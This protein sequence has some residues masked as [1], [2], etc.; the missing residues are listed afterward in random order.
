[1][2]GVEVGT[3]G[4]DFRTFMHILERDERTLDAVDAHFHKAADEFDHPEIK[5]RNK[6]SAFYSNQNAAAASAP[7]EMGDL[8]NALAA[9]A[10]A[11]PAPRSLSV[12]VP[13]GAVA[14]QALQ[15]Q[16]PDGQM[17][18]ATIPAGVQPGQ[19]ITLGY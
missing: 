3:G 18:R 13:P 4:M 7:V 10:P 11:A 19:V 8:K 9:P 2:G 1:V 14:G 5:E 16:A 17:V 15:V 6:S 12:T